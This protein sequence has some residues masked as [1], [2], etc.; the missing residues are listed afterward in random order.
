MQCAKPW[1]ALDICSSI[2]CPWTFNSSDTQLAINFA[3]S[4]ELE[5]SAENRGE[6]SRGAEI[7]GIT[8][9]TGIIKVIAPV[10]GRGDCVNR[11]E[12]AKR[13]WGLWWGS[14]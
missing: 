7:V 13:S 14:L 3:E 6:Q 12:L 1:L 9:N 2:E 4:S 10:S 11:G 5:M 8:E